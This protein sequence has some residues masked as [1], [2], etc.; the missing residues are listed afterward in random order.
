MNIAFQALAA[1]SLDRAQ[2]V[3][4][5]EQIMAS[6]LAPVALT[7]HYVLVLAAV[8]LGVGF[9]RAGVGPRWAAIAIALCGPVD[10]LAGVFGSAGDL[11]GGILS[12]ALLIGGFAAEAWFLVREERARD[13]A[14][15]VRK[16]PVG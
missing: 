13:T 7:G 4:A 11:V 15:A 10:A 3:H 6:P 9:W 12:N 16:V 5:T 14:S 2:M 1:P 8:M